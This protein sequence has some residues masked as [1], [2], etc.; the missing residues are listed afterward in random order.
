M[1]F[2]P[3]IAPFLL[4]TNT[5]KPCDLYVFG[6]NTRIADDTHLA[7]H[8]FYGFTCHFQNGG[9][10]VTGNAV[11]A[12]RVFEL[13]AQEL[14]AEFISARGITVYHR[15][16]PFGLDVVVVYQHIDVLRHLRGFLPV[17]HIL[18]ALRILEEEQKLLYHVAAAP[19][20][21]QVVFDMV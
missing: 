21:E 12:Y 10:E 6:R 20:V 19:V 9:A 4:H 16:S 18:D 14:V 17:G 13:F 1:F 7:G 3:N 5:G 15:L 2:R 8:G 11:V